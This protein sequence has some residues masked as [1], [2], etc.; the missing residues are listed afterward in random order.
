MLCII[1]TSV[2][3]TFTYETIH[4]NLESAL[5]SLS[6]V[7]KYIATKKSNMEEGVLRSQGLLDYLNERNLPLVVSISEDATRISGK[8]HYNSKTNQLVGFVLPTNPDTGMPVTY[9][10]PAN[11]STEILQHFSKDNSIAGFVNVIMAQPLGNVTPFCL[12]IFASNGKYTSID[13]SNRWKYIIKQLS[14]VK[15][16]VIS[17]SSD[18][19][20]RYNSAMRY[21]SLLGAS[22]N[23]FE[24]VRWFKSGAAQNTSNAVPFYVQ[25]TV[26]IANC[27]LE[28]NTLYP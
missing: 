19:D 10:F 4:R 18:S 14:E 8:I 1:S 13:V 22:S 23:L 21:N 11:N 6:A 7:N 9:S 25:D 24:N 2:R 26:H 15:I 28:K 5:P 16:L 27:H 12:L 20:P 3:W 17:I